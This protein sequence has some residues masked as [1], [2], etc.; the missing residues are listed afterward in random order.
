MLESEL[1]QIVGQG[2]NGNQ[3][4]ARALKPCSPA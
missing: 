2:E 4:M 3:S 1:V